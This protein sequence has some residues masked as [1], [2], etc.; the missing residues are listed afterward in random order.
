MDSFNFVFSLYGLVLGLALTEVV[1]GF[2]NVLQE[3]RKIAVGWLTP[4]LGAAVALDIT[5]FWTWAWS[6]R[7]Q[8]PPFYLSLFVGLL[9]AGGYYFVAR[10][11]FPRDF[12][13]W[14]NLDTY[15]FAHKRLVIG[16]VIALN[17]ASEG[18]G[19]ALLRH[20]PFAVTTNIIFLAVFYGVLLA[21]FW[22]RGKALNMA[23]LA[24]FALFNP[25][26]AL[27]LMLTHR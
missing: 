24:F 17:L 13:E 27:L 19:D 8:V 2:G 1:A 14:P 12:A 10:L 3:R 15:Y 25:G 4:L 11:V 18:I 6:M 16:G 20:D 26:A 9:L 22:V 7:A 21:L 23:L 5:S